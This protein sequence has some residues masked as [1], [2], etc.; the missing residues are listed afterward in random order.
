LVAFYHPYWVSKIIR[1]LHTRNT[2]EAQTHLSFAMLLPMVPF[3]AL[4]F[5][6]IPRD[7]S[8]MLVPVLGQYQIMELAV[9]GSPVPVH[10]LL[11]SAASSIALALV[12]LGVA[13]RLYYRERILQ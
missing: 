1:P 5:L 7:A 10:Y 9:L 6:S 2:K 3:F 4:Q 8:T 12:C 11:L 13:I